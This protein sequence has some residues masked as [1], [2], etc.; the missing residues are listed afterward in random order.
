MKIDPNQKTNVVQID[1]TVI[2]AILWRRR[3]LILFGT[4]ATT[5]LAAALS[6]LIPKTYLSE[7]FYQLGNPEKKIDDDEKIIPKKE[8]FIGI[9][10]PLYKKSAPQFFNP[11][12]FYLY[13]KDEKYFNDKDLE[14][15]KASFQI[16][17]DINKWII[18][19]YAFSKGDMREL[20]QMPQEGSNSV[21][22]LSLS[23]EADS[24]KKAYQFVGFFG[25]Y[26]RDCLLY[27]SLY[28]YIKDG[29]SEVISELNKNENKIFKLQFKLQQNTKKMMD[30]KSILTKYPEAAKIESRQLVSVQDEG[31][32]Y[33]GPVTQLV[34]IESTLADQR[35]E[36][37]K[38]KREKEQWV[39]LRQYF[40]KCNDALNKLSIN[41]GMLFS[42][43]KSI[44]SD[45][46]KNK[47]LGNDTIKETYNVLNID[48][49][50]Y[51]LAFF[52]N[53]RFIS[54]PTFPSRYVK[55]RKSIIVIWACFLSL[56]F[57]IVLTLV[58]HWWQTNQKEIKSLKL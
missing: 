22:G 9:P 12:H 17:A 49:Q 19:I 52:T 42:Q 30:I 8:S 1:S 13:A 14:K 23:Y 18:P 11:N 29:Y 46:F 10:I 15:V 41:G 45:I 39:I 21:L 57:F 26:V 50:V 7:G 37:A 20:A 28:D 24:P 51:D 47:D 2:F 38:F 6:F 43:L 32:H 25:Q 31:F 56:C 36:L 4:L 3:R 44:K 48:L 33:L 5:L 35:Q 58:L 55:P 34:G 53:C 40:S 27:V 54:G 16:A